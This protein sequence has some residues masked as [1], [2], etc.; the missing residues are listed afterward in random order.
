MPK[1]R[2]ETSQGDLHLKFS[3][4]TLNSIT[5]CCSFPAKV[6]WLIGTSFPFVALMS[7][8]D[9]ASAHEAL[10]PTGASMWCNALVYPAARA[11]QE[12]LIDGQDY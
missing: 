4:F 12:D 7:N 2:S 11:N 10:H 9:K 1:P 5:A 6:I 8:D 3:Q